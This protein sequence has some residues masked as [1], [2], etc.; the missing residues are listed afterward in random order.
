LSQLNQ[1]IAIYVLRNSNSHIPDTGDFIIID[2]NQLKK[3]TEKQIF[4][5]YLAEQQI[6]TQSTN[7]IQ[8]EKRHVYIP[9]KKPDY[10]LETEPPIRNTDNICDKS[11]SQSVTEIM[12]CAANNIDDIR[13]PA[14]RNIRFKDISL[15]LYNGW[16]QGVWN[17]GR[18]SI[19]FFLVL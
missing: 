18:Y 2:S 12:K 7:K 19:N 10:K 13:L 5:T 14:M 3:I 4:N 6:T 1:K 15:Q 16:I 9:Q 8:I 11:V 17:F